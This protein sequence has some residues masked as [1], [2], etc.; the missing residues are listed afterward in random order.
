MKHEIGVEDIREMVF[1]HPNF[2]EAFFEAA[3]D[4]ND[5]A[6]HIVKG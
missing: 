1:A 2:S 3:L 6:I 5:E 4:V